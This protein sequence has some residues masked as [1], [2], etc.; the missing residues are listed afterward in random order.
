MVS[1]SRGI[2]SVLSNIISNVLEPMAQG[3]KNLGEV[4]SMEHLINTLNQEWEAGGLLPRYKTKLIAADAEVLC[5]FL[6][7]D[8]CAKVVREENL[9]SDLEVDNCNWKGGQDTWR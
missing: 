3:I 1:A 8:I 4:R 7:P 9:K 6:Y 2:N 5:P